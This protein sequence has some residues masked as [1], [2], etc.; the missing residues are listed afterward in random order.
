MT[1]KP[2]TTPDMWI[3]SMA[4]FLN[5]WFPNYAEARAHLEAEGGYLLPYRSQYFVTGA[6]AITELGLDP[7]DPDWERIGWDWARP[8]DPAA[9]ARLR[10][11]RALA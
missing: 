5:H 11:K 10:T 1:A 9:W 2:D 6:D 3:S 8:L 7:D 4:V